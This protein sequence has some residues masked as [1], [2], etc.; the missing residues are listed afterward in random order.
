MAAVLNQVL[1]DSFE[2]VLIR[3]GVTNEAV[4]NALMVTQGLESVHRFVGLT[5]KEIDSMAYG[6][7]KIHRTAAQGPLIIPVYALRNLKALR[8]WAKWQVARGLPVDADLFLVDQLNWSLVRIDF[9]DELKDS[10]EITPPVPSKLKN[11][12][13]QA[14]IPFF[15][16]FNTYC[17]AIRGALKIPIAYVY[18]DHDIVTQDIFD[19][20]YKSSDSQLMNTVL[21]THPKFDSDNKKLWDILQP[22]VNGGHAWPFIKRFAKNEDGRAAFLLLK[23]KAEGSSSVTTRKQKAWSILETTKFTGKNKFSFENFTERLEY[24]FSELEE[25]NQEQQESKKVDILLRNINCSMLSSAIDHIIGNVAMMNDFNSACDYCTTFISLKTSLEMTNSTTRKVSGVGTSETLKMKYTDEEWRELPQAVKDKV[26][27]IRKE[28]KAKS[29]NKT[30]TSTATS[31]SGGPT[32]I[33][34]Y[35][36]KI[37]ALTKKL[38]AQESEESG[39]ESDSTPPANNHTAKAVKTTKKST[40][41]A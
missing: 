1:R 6:I 5:L 26:A 24:A 35:K 41:K 11:V 39:E 20:E 7:A 40:K 38:A 3:C 23:L 30:T 10:T 33:K 9:E 34:G 37:K 16:E 28:K 32:S 22:L 29:G 14:W 8:E 17:T 19:A 12:G 2:Q 13:H 36:R 21:L 31:S 4:V 15:K 27:K 25:C 18:R